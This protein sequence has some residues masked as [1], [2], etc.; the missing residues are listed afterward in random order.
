M[1]SYQERRLQKAVTSWKLSEEGRA[2]YRMPGAYDS[3]VECA[4]L[5]RERRFHD[6]LTV[7]QLVEYLADWGVAGWS[8]S[9]R[10]PGLWYVLRW[11]QCIDIGEFSSHTVGATDVTGLWLAF[12]AEAE[13]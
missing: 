6:G 10:G 11:H 12:V 8:M 5:R 3:D 13:L 9:M 4:V 7:E 1:L 2:W